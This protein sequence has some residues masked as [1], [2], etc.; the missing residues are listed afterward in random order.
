MIN[1]TVLRNSAARLLF[2]ASL[3][4]PHN[5]AGGRL[6]IATFHRVLPAAQ[7]AAYPYP[8][9]VVTPEELDQLLRYFVAHY[10]CGSL[11]VQHR[12]HVGGEA[13]ERPLLAVTFDDGQYDNL[14]YAHPV[15]QR[16]RVKASFF[17][18]VI[19]I[20]SRQLLWH[21]QLGF[22][23]L[24]LLR[25]GE[26]G[27]EVLRRIL[28]AAGLAACGTESQ[29]GRTVAA[30]KT[31]ALEARLRLVQDLTDGAGSITV[32]T[33]ARLMTFEEIA[34]L[35]AAGH[36]IGSHSMTHCLMPEC[37]DAALAYELGESRRILEDRVRCSIE[38]FCY[39]N[40]DADIRTAKAVA[41]A[42]YSRAVTTTWGS[43]GPGDDEFLLRRYDIDAAHVCDT[44]G[45]FVPALLA[46]RMSGYYPGLG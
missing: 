35:A 29:T 38:S 26:A 33:F 32:P 19:A 39:P 3:T 27:R 7:R 45:K 28:G 2:K 17:I 23:V 44:G 1:K 41:N 16:H 12:R 10:D 18:P 42:G 37:D 36:E 22:S 21:D 8:G 43:N 4:A 5:R 24:A 14:L 30:A 34:E 6:S 20:E 13:T 9:L 11:A 40:G 25:R 31:L 46:W 15:L